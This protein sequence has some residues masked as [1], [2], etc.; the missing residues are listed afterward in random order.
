MKLLVQYGADLNKELGASKDKKSPLMVAAGAG[1]L[2]VVKYLVS[3]GA[4]VEQKG[5]HCCLIN[6]K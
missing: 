2:D 6:C 5:R 1:H 4:L 3:K